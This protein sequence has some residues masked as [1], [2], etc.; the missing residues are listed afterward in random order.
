VFILIFLSNVFC[1]VDH[2]TLP[3]CSI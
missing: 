2:G 3:G 1:N